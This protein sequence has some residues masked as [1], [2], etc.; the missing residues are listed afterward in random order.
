MAYSKDLVITL[1]IML[2][3]IILV[4]IIVIMLQKL[5]YR[6]AF[7]PICNKFLEQNCLD[8]THF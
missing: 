2:R 5:Y 7:L 1:V 6:N 4:T 3:V 8:K